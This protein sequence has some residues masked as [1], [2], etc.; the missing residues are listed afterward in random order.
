MGAR[1]ARGAT[2]IL[3]GPHLVVVVHKGVIVAG[4]F[5]LTR[6]AAERRAD[7]CRSAHD[8]MNVKVDV[9]SLADL[10][11]HHNAAQQREVAELE[12]ISAL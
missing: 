1:R 2:E 6:A 9:Y 10:I 3:K 5:H 12:R 8:G 4:W 11:L 7:K